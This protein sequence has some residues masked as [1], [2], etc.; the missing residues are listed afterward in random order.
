MIFFF[1]SILVVVV[2]VVVLVLVDVVRFFS[3]SWKNL[4]LS[5]VDVVLCVGRE[6]KEGGREREVR[7]FFFWYCL[8]M[9]EAFVP[10][11]SSESK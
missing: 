7:L 8:S 9:L 6:T 4:M 10:P 3:F 2:V 1:L 5:F 11:V